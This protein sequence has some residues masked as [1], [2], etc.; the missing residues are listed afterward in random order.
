MEQLLTEVDAKNDE[1]T[2][3]NDDI[4][5]MLQ[6]RARTQATQAAGGL[7]GE[8]NS[9]VSRLVQQVKETQQELDRRSEE[10]AAKTRQVGELRQKSDE[11]VRLVEERTQQSADLE[12]RM[13]DAQTESQSLA[14][15]LKRTEKEAQMKAERIRAL[16]QRHAEK[17]KQLGQERQRSELNSRTV[18]DLEQQV[19][20]LEQKRKLLEELGDELEKKSLQI[21]DREEEIERTDAALGALNT[22][23]D[24]IRA[25][26][27]AAKADVSRLREEAQSKHQELVSLVA[28]TARTA[29]GR[30][31]TLSV[32]HRK[33]ILCGTFVWESSALNGPFR[34]FP[35][36]AGAFGS[37][38]RRC[39]P[40][41]EASRGGHDHLEPR[42][43]KYTAR[44]RAKEAG[45]GA[46]QTG[47]SRFFFDLPEHLLTSFH[48]ILI[49]KFGGNLPTIPSF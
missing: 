34:R 38:K 19:S 22:E 24:A 35:A 6:D 41:H 32:S 31:S 44:V 39:T 26:T 9:S 2:R 30:L 28:E 43:R 18:K 15:T 42:A 46:P 4:K 40:V 37:R 47:G 29:L 1:L 27:D 3:K 33:S 49:V 21:L 14:R 11:H 7:T 10:K 13:E 23:H 45:A 5:R 20:Q 12:Q 16:E 17:E 8:K 36:R 25:A 48:T